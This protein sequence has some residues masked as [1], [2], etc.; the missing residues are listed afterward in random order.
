MARRK[1][2]DM[3]DQAQGAVK[4]IDAGEFSDGHVFIERDGTVFSGFKFYANPTSVD[5][6]VYQLFNGLSVEPDD[7]YLAASYSDY[8]PVQTFHANQG[9]YDAGLEFAVEL[10]FSRVNGSNATSGTGGLE[11]SAFT[12]IYKQDSKLPRYFGIQSVHGPVRMTY[13]LHQ[14][15]RIKR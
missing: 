13:E 15:R 14:Q 9:A 10:P 12:N 2:I 7:S 11:G 8:E 1:T 6:P 5:G 4:L 3:G